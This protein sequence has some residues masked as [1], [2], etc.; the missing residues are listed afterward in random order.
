MADSQI[1]LDAELASVLEEI[2]C[3]DRTAVR[4]LIV[5]GLYREGL[6]SSGKGAEVL[7]LARRE[8]IQRAGARGIPYFQM[9]AGELR[10]EIDQAK[11][12]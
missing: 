7:G 10:Q 2:G 6:V 1:P 3:S 8:F 12:L 11:K 9:T 4:E 5:F